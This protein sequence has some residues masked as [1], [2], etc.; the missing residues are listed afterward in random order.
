MQVLRYW[1]KKQIQVSYPKLFLEPT[2]VLQYEQHKPFFPSLSVENKSG[3]ELKTR[4][5]DVFFT[6]FHR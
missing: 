5:D 4:S 6:L 2:D 3:L 1:N